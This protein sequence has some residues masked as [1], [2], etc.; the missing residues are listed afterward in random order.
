MSITGG[1]EGL[2]SVFQV[3]WE[4]LTEEVFQPKNYVRLV[5][6]IQAELESTTL[7]SDNSSVARAVSVIRQTKRTLPLTRSA[8]DRITHP[9]SSHDRMPLNGAAYWTSTILRIW[10]TLEVQLLN[11]DILEDGS[12][13][14]PAPVVPWGIS[15]DISTAIEAYF[16]SQRL[17]QTTRNLAKIS[18]LMTAAYLCRTHRLGIRWTD[19]L[20]DHLS[21]NWKARVIS[22]Y[23]HKIFL[24]NQLRL[25]A[26]PVIPQAVLEEALDTLN[27]L[28]P[29]GDEATKA[30]L[31]RQGRP[32][33]GLGY[34][35]R[36]RLL[37]LSKYHYW[38]DRVSDLVEVMREE[39]IGLQQLSLAKDGRN[40]L[41]F[42]TFWMAFFVAVLT[43]TSIVFGVVQVVYAIKQYNLAVAQACAAPGARGMLPKYCS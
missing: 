12:G 23:Q 31:L 15:T 28:F 19:N 1:Q 5:E 30:F 25:T 34:C 16:E 38:R 33:Y 36:E 26:R 40:F 20:A 41:Q 32:F 2:F 27:L 43:I 13:G 17:S 7:S 8:L 10:L 9:Q 22:I 39:P 24:R 42:A 37:D 11:S 18:H 3:F 21:I 14:Y 35:G 4:G 6:F 29:Y